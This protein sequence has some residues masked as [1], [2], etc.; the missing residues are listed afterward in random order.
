MRRSAR[1]SMRCRRP[2]A[3]AER[4]IIQPV[5]AYA[6]DLV[7]NVAVFLFSGTSNDDADYV[8]YIAT[9]QELD[10]KAVGRDTPIGIVVVSPGNP[11][12][13]ALWRKRI[14]E[15]AGG[16]RSRALMIVVSESALVRGVVR[17]VSWIKPLPLDSAAV[18]TFEEARDVA[19]KHRGRRIRALDELHQQ[20][21]NA[22]LFRAPNR[23][24]R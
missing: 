18:A 14:A 19:E 12:P 17:A 10:R 15:A 4:A 1:C 5:F 8:R 7:E 6:Y 21:K 3:H 9:F 2:H 20:A 11:P 24:A 13:N 23:A 16:L 22:A